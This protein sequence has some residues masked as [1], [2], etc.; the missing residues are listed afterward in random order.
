MNASSKL[1]RAL[2]D[3]YLAEMVLLDDSCG[4]SL[5]LVPSWN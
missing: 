5:D 4:R 3:G 2:L 1:A